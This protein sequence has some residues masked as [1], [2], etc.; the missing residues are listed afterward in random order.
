MS[1]DLGRV[2]RGRV[3]PECDRTCLPF[4]CGPVVVDRC[5][6]CG[7]IWFDPGEIGVFRERLRELDLTELVPIGEAASS[8]PGILGCPRCRGIVLESF[9]YGVNTG[10]MPLRC[11]R[12]E[13]I[14][15]AGDELR[16]FLGMARLAQ[17]MRP[18]VQGMAKAL[19]E[20][21]KTRERLRRAERLSDG[22]LPSGIFYSSW[23]YFVENGI[24]ALIEWLWKKFRR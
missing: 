22:H 15:L 17:E 1:T 18:H 9:H 13:G 6:Q 8:Q 12:C 10:V 14:W 4:N 19:K 3:C 16:V 23:E 20:T 5:P 7:G 21:A 11:T 2:R 24:L